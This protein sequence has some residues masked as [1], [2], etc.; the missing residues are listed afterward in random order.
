MDFYTFIVK[1]Y[2]ERVIYWEKLFSIYK[3][4][5]E[6]NTDYKG[7]AQEHN[8]SYENIRLLKMRMKNKKLI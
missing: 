6:G 5:K 2:G 1:Y 8:T 7:I 4:F 3:E